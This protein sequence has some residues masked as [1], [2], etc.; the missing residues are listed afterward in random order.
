M[1][2]RHLKYVIAVAEEKNFTRAA[3][4][5]RIAQPPLSQQIRQLEEELGL[6]LFRRGK[7]ITEPTEA[8]WV[9]YHQA[10]QIVQAS[11]RLIEDT[12]RAGRGEVGCLRIGYVGALSSEFLPRALRKFRALFPEVEIQLHDLLEA[13]QT[14]ALLRGELD[15]GFMT[16][17]SG[18][19]GELL[20][21]RPFRKETMGV[22][23]WKDHPLAAKLR[24]S[25]KDL[26]S[27]RL[28]AISAAVSP[29]GHELLLKTYRAAGLNT[30]TMIEAHNGPAIIDLVSAGFGVALAPSIFKQRLGTE[31]VFREL[32]KPLPAFHFHYFWRKDN[33]SPVLRQFLALLAKQE[34]A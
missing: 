34:T 31:A 32:A 28:I 17:E 19:P 22:L 29:R 25:L 33:V 1:E 14:K 6:P 11:V 15:V 5:L 21:H 13:D 16:M 7:R 18:E 24:V 3:K 9:F 2:L 4:R 26:R 20:E 10:R 12:R 8:G 30:D 27:E 23:L